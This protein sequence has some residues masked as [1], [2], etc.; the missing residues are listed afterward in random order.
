MRRVSSVSVCLCCICCMFVCE[1]TNSLTGVCECVM[2]RICYL[3]MMT[4]SDGVSFLF[5][6]LFLS[7]QRLTRTQRDKNESRPVSHCRASYFFQTAQ[8]RHL[9][10]PTLYAG[11][12]LHQGTSHRGREDTALKHRDFYLKQRRRTTQI[13]SVFCGLT[14]T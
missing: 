9:H 11:N 5:P 10:T 3:S 6:Q 4:G 1:R 13:W 8:V 12:R 2:L 14:C 7:Q